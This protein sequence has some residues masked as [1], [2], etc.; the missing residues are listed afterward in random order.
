MVNS[1]INTAKMQLLKGFKHIYSVI[2]HCSDKPQVVLG[3]WG[4]VNTRQSDLKVLYS[5][6]DHCGTCAEYIISKEK[7]NIER[8]N[9][10]Y[11]YEFELLKNEYP[12]TKKKL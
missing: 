6:E 9:E 1:I 11:H 5:N 7:E 2:K 10:Y 3:R 8:T 4:A 12:D